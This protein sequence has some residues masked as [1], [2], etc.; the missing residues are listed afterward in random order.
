MRTVSTFGGAVATEQLLKMSQP[1]I[2]K[3]LEIDETISGWRLGSASF[4]RRPCAVH[5]LTQEGPRGGQHDQAATHS[6]ASASVS[7]SARRLRV[8]ATSLSHVPLSVNSALR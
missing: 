3:V 1:A 2:E 8:A 6:N 4:S 7:Q 5:T